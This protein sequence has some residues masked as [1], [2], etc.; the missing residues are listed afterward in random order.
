LLRAMAS[1]ALRVVWRSDLD[2]FTQHKYFALPWSRT[3]P[4]LALAEKSGDNADPDCADVVTLRPAGS[5]E[6]TRFRKNVF[7]YGESH[8]LGQSGGGCAEL[9]TWP[10]GSLMYEL[11]QLLCA[12]EGAKV[13]NH[14]VTDIEKIVQDCLSLCPQGGLADAL[15]G[16]VL[17]D[18]GQNPVVASSIGLT[19]HTQVMRAGAEDFPLMAEQSSPEWSSTLGAW[20]DVVQVGESED[21]FFLSIRSP[22]PDSKS[23]L[24]FL[25][26]LRLRLLRVFG[27]KVDFN[28][29][30]HPLASGDFIVNFAPVACMQRI[31]VPK[32]EGCMGLDF[33]F[34]NPET[35]ERLTE[36]RLPC[37]SVDASHGKGNVLAASDEFWHMALEG[38]P[39]L[40]RLYDFNRRPGTRSEVEA[41]LREVRSSV[42]ET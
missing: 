4:L 30:C 22:T 16:E 32:G 26:N 34:Q 11:G 20:L 29:T 14:W 25:V 2:R 27:K 17:H 6:H 35:G 31:K 41:Y 37:A 40:A 3:V 12:D 33:D 13:P 28:V 18:V 19:Q 15:P 10:V 9:P 39:M 7:S 8:G 21:A 23:L 5:P 24:E 36:R 1:P 38:R 42:G